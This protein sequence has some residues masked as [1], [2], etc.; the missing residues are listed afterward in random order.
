MTFFSDIAKSIDKALETNIG[1]SIL[2]S[3]LGKSIDRALSTTDVGRS[4][5][6]GLGHARAEAIG[7]S[8]YPMASANTDNIIT[9]NLESQS[10]D[11]SPRY[12]SLV[13]RSSFHTGRHDDPEEKRQDEVR[14]EINSGH[15]F[16]SFAQ[17]RTQNTVKW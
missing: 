15:R 3:D 5:D 12:I 7:A 1:Q 17:E 2:T 16:Q 10:C 6:K 4:I 11:L 8:S 13:L 9:R 14:A